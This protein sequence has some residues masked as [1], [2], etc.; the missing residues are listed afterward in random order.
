MQTIN[1][2]TKGKPL[3]I[4]QGAHN[5]GQVAF[6]AEKI[7]AYTLG[8][9]SLSPRE[10]CVFEF[11][12]NGP[13]KEIPTRKK[14]RAL[15]LD[16][17]IKALCSRLASRLLWIPLPESDLCAREFLNVRGPELEARHA[18]LPSSGLVG[19]GGLACEVLTGNSRISEFS[20]C[21]WETLPCFQR[22]G[23]QKAWIT[24]DPTAALIGSGDISVDLTGTL[25]HAAM[26]VGL[27]VKSLALWDY[28]G[29]SVD[30]IWEE[31]QGDR[32]RQMFSRG[33]Q[34]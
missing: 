10:H 22:I 3:V 16:S 23:I 33:R 29:P 6:D 28:K 32:G 9:L 19:M 26:D 12:Y 24:W 8:R 15:F 34:E 18:A 4:L 31:Y 27:P 25:A 14:E 11:V 20:D 13:Q 7:L 1:T 2:P 5:R 30:E 21:E 17:H